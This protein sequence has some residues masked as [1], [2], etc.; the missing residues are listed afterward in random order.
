LSN[1]LQATI[2]PNK[3]E[4]ER[5]DMGGDLVVK[6]NGT[7]LVTIHYDYRYIDNAGQWGLAKEIVK[8][9]REELE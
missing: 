4:V 7:S 1:V 5:P 6:V 9:L 3:W 8:I 2:I